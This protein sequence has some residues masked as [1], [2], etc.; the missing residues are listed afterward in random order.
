MPEHRDLLLHWHAFALQG[1]QLLGHG[2]IHV[3]A[4][5]AMEDHVELLRVEHDAARRGSWPRR[6]WQP[7]RRWYRHLEDYEAAITRLRTGGDLADTAG[8]VECQVISCRAQ[9][10]LRFCPD[11]DCRTVVAV[12]A[13][14]PWCW[15]CGADLVSFEACQWLSHT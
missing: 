1:E 2:V 9:E 12:D 7:R 10:C 5:M 6:W 15:V 3:D 13:A 4:E 11:A 14:D 8:G